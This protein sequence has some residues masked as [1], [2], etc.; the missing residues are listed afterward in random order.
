MLKEEKSLSSPSKSPTRTDRS[1]ELNIHLS[2]W[3]KGL[4]P[5]Y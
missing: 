5:H 4:Y 2:A 3:R 1:T